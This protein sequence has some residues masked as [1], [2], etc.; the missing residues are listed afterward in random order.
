MIRN[1]KLYPWFFAAH[2]FIG[3]MPVF[4]LY[5]S[6]YI[7]LRE[8]LLL[9]SIYYIAVVI[10]EVPSGYFSDVIGRRLTLLISSI[11]LLL[12][13]IVF[14]IGDTFMLFALGQILFAGWMAFQSG[15][16][17]V[18]HYET[19]KSLDKESEYGDREAHLG[20]IGYITGGIAALIGGWLASYDLVYAFMITIG[21]AIVAIICCMLFK[22]PN[23]AGF[24]E[25]HAQSF[26]NQLSTV[27]GYFKKGPLGWLFLYLVFMY[28][29]AHV[30]YEFYQPY[31]KLLESDNL[32]AG[33][34]APFISG[35][36]YAISLFI[37]AYAS[38][39]S[40]KWMRRFGVAQVLIAAM[41]ALIAVTALMGTVLHP[42]MIAVILLR[43]AP[44]GL[45]KAPTNAIITPQIDTGQRAT[46]H[47]VISLMSRLAFFATLLALSYIVPK[48]NIADWSTLS[49]LLL[50]TAGSS[51]LVAI[52]FIFSAKR[53]AFKIE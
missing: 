3:W 25:Q 36:V 23:S 38:G 15:T 8:V 2:Y 45:I 35:L 21:A 43:G 39:Q 30:P 27:G 11:F 20:K 32:L 33:S 49:K 19:L 46:L 12:A 40:M 22:E 47:S 14:V 24:K 28:A 29:I 34:N 50:V 48:E 5:F 51:M 9:E 44:R 7:G 16:N 42:F 1:L 18:F 4:F 10:L 17:T 6:S 31:L 13:S 37:S 41:I 52:F 26:I 53:H